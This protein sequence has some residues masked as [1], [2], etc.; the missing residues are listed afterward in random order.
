MES[1][2]SAPECDPDIIQIFRSRI[3]KFF[4]PVQGGIDLRDAAL[5]IESD[6]L[7]ADPDDGQERAAAAAILDAISEAS[8][9]TTGPLVFYP[10]KDD[11]QSIVRARDL[12]LDDRIDLRRAGLS[13]LTALSKSPGAMSSQTRSALIRLNE[14]ILTEDVWRS[15]SVELVNTLDADWL[16]CLNTI[17]QLRNLAVGDFWEHTVRSMLQPTVASVQRCS[18]AMLC[19]VIHKDKIDDWLDGLAKKAVPTS[20]FCEEYLRALGHIPLGHRCGLS[21]AL[22]ARK[23]N[24]LG[25]NNAQSIIEWASDHPM[26]VARYHACE[27]LIAEFESLTEEQVDCVVSWFWDTVLLTSVVEQP[28][29]AVASWGLAELLSRYYQCWLDLRIPADHGEPIAAMAWWMAWRVAETWSRARLSARRF[30]EQV[31]KH[32][33][34]PLH[35]IWGLVH[36][37]AQA[38]SLHRMATC[39][40]SPWAA[41]LVSSVSSEYVLD[42]LLIGPGTGSRDERVSSLIRLAA[43]SVELSLE[44]DA[45]RFRDSLR[46]VV[47]WAVAS[48]SEPSAHATFVSL[49]EGFDWSTSDALGQALNSLNTLDQ[50]K[51]L[52][53]CHAIRRRA[54]SDSLDGDE[55]WAIVSD[56][57]WKAK[58]WLEIDLIAAQALGEGLVT[59]AARHDPEWAPRL[60][61][62]FAGL[63]EI[64]LGSEEERVAIFG[65]LIRSTCALDAPSGLVRL[66]RG[67]KGHAYRELAQ[68]VKQNTANLIPFSGGWDAGRIRALLV[69]L[70]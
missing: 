16:L 26:P 61:H 6:V 46:T 48:K 67:P 7:R 39:G 37:Q 70:L 32:A 9:S 25:S 47:G 60:P 42:R 45:Y 29:P 19:P 59:I 18:P 3:A 62:L 30:E 35:T 8:G 5:L 38:G 21:D 11:S 68:A 52:W 33:F 34:K 69:D 53:I 22:D 54:E 43:K 31:E 66:L 56:A 17:R 51:Q 55:L 49:T 4:L 64:R 63:A 27:A 1:D 10:G 20:Q 44:S 36:P 50:A 14:A 2:A 15:A 12:L 41:S 58:T 40:L 57:D 23:R 13:H 24:D 28:S 65:L